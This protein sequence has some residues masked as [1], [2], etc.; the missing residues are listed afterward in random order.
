MTT[1]GGTKEVGEF[2]LHLQCPW[3]LL[4]AAG[5]LVASYDSTAEELAAVPS[6]PLFCCGV[7]VAASGRFILDFCT[8]ETLIVEGD[9]PDC[10]EYWR[11]FRPGSNEPHFVV[12]S[13]C[14]D[15]Q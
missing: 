7:V 11:L 15:R 5:S 14:A 13:A 1:R 12:G 6:L 8:G 2:A 9:D 3:Q 10:E 4:D